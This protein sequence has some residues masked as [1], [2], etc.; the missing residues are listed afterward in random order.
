MEKIEGISL[1]DSFHFDDEIFMETEN[2]FTAL[3]LHPPPEIILQ[4]LTNLVKQ[5]PVESVFLDPINS[6]T[7]KRKCQ[8]NNKVCEM[9]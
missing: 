6:K 2:S 9:I 7:T 5:E 1:L 3:L 8:E 4:N